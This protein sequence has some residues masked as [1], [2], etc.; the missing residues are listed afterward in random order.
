MKNLPG[1]WRAVVCGVLLLGLVGLPGCRKTASVERPLTPVR[2]QRADWASTQTATTYSA[3]IEPYAQVDL[4][5]KSNG[6]V[7]SVRQVG[8]AGGMSRSIDQGDYVQKGTVLATVEEDEFKQKLSQA[9]AQLSRSQADYT[10]AKLS[11]DRASTLYHAGAMTKPD[12]DNATAQIAGAE[13]SVQSAK[14]TVS[15][16]NIAL[17]YCQL[18][19]PFSGWIVARYIDVGSLVNPATRSFTLADTRYVKAVFGVPDSTLGSIRLGT[20][21]A[22]TVEALAQQFHGRVSSISPA[23]DPKSRVFSVEVTIPNPRYVLKSGMIASIALGG[24][25]AAATR[26]L[27]VPLSAV[28]HSPA[29]PGGYAVFVASQSGGSTTVQARDVTLGS[30][31]GNMIAVAGGIDAGEEVVTKGADM[32]KSGEQV[33]IV[34]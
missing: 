25:Q 27:L 19:A 33:R 1:R 34:P 9:D 8:G 31:Y 22:V 15:E 7:S 18:R 2:V 14:A 10:R 12:F 5:F 17:G 23:A 3:N 16:A 21:E 13:A 20:P 26:N 30:A 11:F 32:V 29:N 24:Q 28:I 6:Y 4:N